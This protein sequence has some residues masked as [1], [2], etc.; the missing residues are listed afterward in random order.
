MQRAKEGVVH[1]DKATKQARLTTS[2][3][4]GWLMEGLLESFA[5]GN[6]RTEVPAWP[7]L[8]LSLESPSMAAFT[9]G[10]AWEQLWALF[11][12]GRHLFSAL[13]PLFRIFPA[14]VPFFRLGPKLPPPCVPFSQFS[15][16]SRVFS[17]PAQTT[18][19]L[20]SLPFAGQWRFRNV[21]FVLRVAVFWMFFGFGFRRRVLLSVL[22][23]DLRP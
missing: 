6:Q 4:L 14:S 23:K 12:S 22:R 17:V 15:W 1:G 19:I 13:A 16:I 18:P 11:S 21:W 20:G 10:L 5:R 8:F 9:T 7:L 3:G 2:A